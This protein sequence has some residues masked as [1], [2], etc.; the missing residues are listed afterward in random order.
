MKVFLVGLNSSYMHSNPALY[1]L[2][3]MS[4]PDDIVIQTG[5][6]T[7]NSSEEDILDAI[8]AYQPQIIGFSAY[9]WNIEYLKK[10]AADLKRIMP[11][12]LLLMGGPQAT[13][14]N[15][16]LLEACPAIDLL[17]LG[18]GERLLPLLLTDL[19]QGHS[20]PTHPG[21]L[22]QG[23]EDLT[24]APYEDFS[25]LPFLYDAADLQELKGKI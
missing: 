18:E 13:G 16:N 8:I 15:K 5:Q 11:S 17:I 4:Y 14:E 21:L 9:I 10:L 6:W 24:F 12:V 7:I 22:W 2:K 25:D 3:K 19:A 23:Q 20:Q 1:M